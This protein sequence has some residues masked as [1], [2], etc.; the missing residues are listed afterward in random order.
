MFIRKIIRWFF[1]GYPSGYGV[2]LTWDENM[3]EHMR[4]MR[5]HLGVETNVKVV[6][7]ALPLTQL[8][9]EKVNEGCELVI[10][11]PDGE[12]YSV[13]LSWKVVKK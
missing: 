4:V 10:K 12:E 7:F 11:A 1:T 3:E 8:I 6:E 5:E 9:L 2:K 13:N